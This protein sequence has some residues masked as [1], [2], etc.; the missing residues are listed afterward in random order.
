LPAAEPS[1]PAPT[2]KARAA[3]AQLATTLRGL[4]RH[5]DL[6]RLLVAHLFYN[7]AIVALIVLSGLYMEAALGMSQAQIL[8]MGIVL[9]V[10]SGL[11]ALLFGF[12]DD[13]LGAKTAL[14]GSTLLLLA[15]AL[16]AIAVPTTGAFALAAGLVGL[17][18]G[19]N[20]AASR[21]MLARFVDPRRGAEY[22]G[23]FAL[24]GKATVWMGPLLFSV[25]LQH[26]GS[27]RAA[28]VP[29]LGML[30][31]GLVIVCSIDERRG[32]AAARGG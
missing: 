6:L 24:S 14:V 26:T 20:Q 22:Y 4:P 19:P 5:R 31:V 28:F 32:V 16:L 30:A 18:M 29:L 11:G 2:R 1:A 9:N 12:V 17:G 21:T 10:V 13:A 8:A 23:L 7:D 25:V 3:L 27:H 15:G